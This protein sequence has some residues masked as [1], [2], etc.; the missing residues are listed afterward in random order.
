MKMENLPFVVLKKLFKMMPNRNETIK[1]SQVCRSWRAAYEMG[2]DRESLYLNFD[3]FLPLHELLFYTNEPVVESLFLK[4]P[5]NPDLPFLHSD[6]TRVHFP[7]LKKLVI[8]PFDRNYNHF[9]E[10]I[11]E[12]SFQKQLNCFQMLEHVEIH[13]RRLLTEDYEIA[14]PKLKI[15]LF[16]GRFVEENVQIILNTPSLKVLG[17]PLFKITNFKFLF[18]H[19]LKYLDAKNPGNRFKF[20]TE[21]TNLECLVIFSK[22]R[23]L[24]DNEEFRQ[25]YQLGDDFLGSLPNLKFLFV[26]ESEADYSALEAEK[27]KFKLDNL[28]ISDHERD[29]FEFD[30]VNW[31]RYVENIE[32]LRSWPCGFAVEFSKLLNSK[33]PIRHFKANHLRISTLG[34]RQVTD[35]SLLVEFLKNVK[36]KYLKLK[37][38]FNLGNQSFFDQIADFLTLKQ[39]SLYESAWTEVSDPSVLSRL[40]CL[41]YKLYFSQ[42]PRQVVLAVLTNPSSFLINFYR[43]S[44]LEDFNEDLDLLPDFMESYFHYI[45]KKKNVFYCCNCKWTS[46]RDPNC[47]EDLIGG[48]I[49]HVENKRSSRNMTGDEIVEI[50]W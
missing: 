28:R 4:L 34:V 25:T 41:E 35:Q 39:L 7:N 37:Y 42:L 8:F 49:Q 13:E 5:D 2:I 46:A 22:L 23:G 30:Y 17:I 43:C 38:D 10:P 31:R 12:F 44:G 27:R 29:L 47:S 24:D 11:C 50:F 32:Q 9:Y 21:F 16:V 1:C 6:A 26:P 40:N 18:P 14:L 33:I 19:K 15:F 20:D 48:T 3:E 36:I 45:K